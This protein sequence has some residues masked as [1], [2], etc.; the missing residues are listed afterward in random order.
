MNNNKKEQRKK[1]VEYKLNVDG[2][3]TV[4]EEG[5]PVVSL[6]ER[7]LRDRQN[8]ILFIDLRTWNTNLFDKKFVEFDPAQ[9]QKI[10]KIYHD[11]Q[12]RDTSKYHNVPELCK[13]VKMEDL[14]RKDYSLVPSKY[15]DFIDHDMEIDYPKEMA[16]IQNEMKDLIREEI[17][18]QQLLKEA[19][20]GIGYE[21]E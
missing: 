2:S 5:K 12:G 10:K 20:K 19:F 6:V 1:C 3:L 14:I 16:R 15:I 7:H 4:D 11:W 18:T 8:E 9:V 17:E 21:I 13:A